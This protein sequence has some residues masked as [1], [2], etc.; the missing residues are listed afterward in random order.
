MTL[1]IFSNPI[2]SKVSQ[3]GPLTLL[4]QLMYFGNYGLSNA[5]LDQFLKIPASEHHPTVIM[6]NGPKDC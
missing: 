5:W 4:S 6:L 1:F 2:K 3:V